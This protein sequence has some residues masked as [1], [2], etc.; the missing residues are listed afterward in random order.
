MNLLLLL[1]VPLIASLCGPLYPNRVTGTPVAVAGSL[2]QLILSGILPGAYLDP[3][4]GPA[5]GTFRFQQSFD[6]FP[7]IRN[8]FSVGVD[9]IGIAMILL[10]P[11]WFGGSPVSVNI[12]E[13]AEE[14]S[15]S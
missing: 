2:F 6:W 1:I 14:F 4:A 12:K 5:D 9:G 7:G 11:L 15:F 8:S 13:R 10:T 3:A